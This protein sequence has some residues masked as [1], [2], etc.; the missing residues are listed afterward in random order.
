VGPGVSGGRVGER[1]WCYGAQSYR[2]FGTAA[3]YVVVPDGLAVFADGPVR[4]LVVLG[5]QVGGRRTGPGR[6]ES[7]P[8][9]R[10][11]LAVCLILVLQGCGSVLLRRQGCLSNTDPPCHPRGR[12]REAGRA[13]KQGTLVLIMPGH[14]LGPAPEEV[15]LW[16]RFSPL[17]PRLQPAAWW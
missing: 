2:P 14:L 1:V 11:Y 8:V 10:I 3:E 17:S 16:L 6:P 12:R 15:Q 4:G 5:R 9:M 7:E 13:G